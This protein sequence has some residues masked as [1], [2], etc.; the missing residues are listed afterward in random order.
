MFERQT[1]FGNMSICLFGRR[2]G[3]NRFMIAIFNIDDAAATH[4]L[5]DSQIKLW[6]QCITLCAC[7]YEQFS[8]FI[9]FISI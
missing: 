6:A 4:T 5:C 7:L 2:I 8:N 9:I 1:H 3:A